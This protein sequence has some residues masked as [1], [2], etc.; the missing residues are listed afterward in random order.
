MNRILHILLLLVLVSGTFLSFAACSGA[1]VV[2]VDGTPAPPAVTPSPT[3]PASSPATPS[4]AQKYTYQVIKVYP[5]DA[6]AFTQG[7]VF[8]NGF[9]YEGT[10]LYGQSSL[11]RVDLETGKVLQKIELA[12]QYFGEGIT[13]YRDRLIQLTWQNGIGFVY[14]KDNF[15]TT[16]QFYYPGEGWGITHDGTR[17]IMSDGTATLRFLDA[18]KF[19]IIG[20]VEVHDNGV[21]VRGLNELEFIKGR[22]YANVWTTDRVAIIDPASGSVAAWLDLTGLLMTQ[23]P[24]AGS[25]DV[26]NGIAY[27]PEGDRLFVTGKLCQ[28]LFE[29]KLIQIK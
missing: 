10:G 7:L 5:H 14:D 20:Q 12:E 17:L 28:W 19:T 11:R 3:A 6:S 16:S 22:V 8:K 15:K 29:I 13:I 18:E 26:L 2:V 27:E 1:P 21:P 24:Q 25:V 9:I 23:S 4:P